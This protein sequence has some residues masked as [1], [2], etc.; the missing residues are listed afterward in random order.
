MSGHT[1][2][3]VH[4]GDAIMSTVTCHQPADAFCRLADET[5]EEWWECTDSPACQQDCGHAPGD[6]IEDE[7]GHPAGRHCINGHP[8]VQRPTCQAVENFAA[9]CGW[10]LSESYH[11]P[12]GVPVHDGPIRTWWQDGQ[13]WTYAEVTA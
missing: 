10:N 2:A 12:K 5:C 7:C 1:I 9:E 3:H 13:V 8:L 11:G 4:D 6:H